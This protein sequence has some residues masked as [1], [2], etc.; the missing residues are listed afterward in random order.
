[1]AIPARSLFSCATMTSALG[2][3]M[4]RSRLRRES[5]SVANARSS[6]ATSAS[7]SPRSALR[8]RMSGSGARA[9]LGG[10][11]LLSKE[12]TL[13]GCVGARHASPP[14]QHVR[15]LPADDACVAPTKASCRR[16]LTQA[17]GEHAHDVEC[18]A[19][20]AVADLLPA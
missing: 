3:A 15:L 1:M 7:R 18:V 14:S 16:I 8:M 2:E 11:D 6:S 9:S 13:L 10:M 17:H 4:K 19:A 5:W 12:N 20:G